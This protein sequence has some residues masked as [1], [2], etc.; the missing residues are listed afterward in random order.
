[1]L[2]CGLITKSFLNS[3]VDNIDFTIRTSHGLIQICH[4]VLLLPL[5]YRTVCERM[6]DSLVGAEQAVEEDRD[7]V[8]RHRNEDSLQRCQIVELKKRNKAL[9]ARITEVSK[10]MLEKELEMQEID[11]GREKAQILEREAHKEQEREAGRGLMEILQQQGL[12]E[13]QN[14]ALVDTLARNELKDSADV[15]A[16]A[17]LRLQ[18]NILEQYV[19]VQEDESIKDKET[20]STLTAE[21]RLLQERAL[22]LDQDLNS[23]LY[24]A[25]ALHED[26]DQGNGHASGTIES[27]DKE[28]EAEAEGEGEE[29]V[30][31]KEDDSEEDQSEEEFEQ[32]RSD[33]HH[34][35]V[36]GCVK[37]RRKCLQTRAVCLESAKGLSNC[38]PFGRS[39]T[40]DTGGIS[41]REIDSQ[42]SGDSYSLPFFHDEGDLDEDC[43]PPSPSRDMQTDDCNSSRGIAKAKDKDNGQDIVANDHDL[44]CGTQ[45]CTPTDGG[46]GCR[47]ADHLL[48]Q[49]DRGPDTTGT[50]ENDTGTMEN[51]TGTVE[52]NA[53]CASQLHK[54]Q[55]ADDSCSYSTSKDTSCLKEGEGE[56]GLKQDRSRQL[57]I[58]NAIMCSSGEDIIAM[59]YI[60]SEIA[61]ISIR[62][63]VANTQLGQEASKSPES[64][65]DCIMKNFMCPS[66]SFSVRPANVCTFNAHL[67]NS[68]SDKTADDDRTHHET[69]IKVE[70]GNISTRISSSGDRVEKFRD[71]LNLHVERFEAL[72]VAPVKDTETSLS[73][74]HRNGKMAVFLESSKPRIE[75]QPLSALY[76]NHS[77]ELDVES[78][79][80]SIGGPGVSQSRTAPLSVDVTNCRDLRRNVREFRHPR[81]IPMKGATVPPHSHLPS[82]TSALSRSGVSVFPRYLSDRCETSS[83]V[84]LTEER[85]SSGKD[86]LTGANSISGNLRKN[87][88]AGPDPEQIRAPVKA[89]GNQRAVSVSDQRSNEFDRSHQSKTKP[90]R[91]TTT[92]TFT[93]PTLDHQ[94]ILLSEDVN[95]HGNARVRKVRREAFDSN[96]LS[97]SSEHS[98]QYKNCC[99]EVEYERYLYHFR[100]EQDRVALGLRAQAQREYYQSVIVPAPAPSV[101]AVVPQSGLQEHFP[102][103][104]SVSFQVSSSSRPQKLTQPVHPFVFPNDVE[105]QQVLEVLR[106]AKAALDISHVDMR[107]T[108]TQQKIIDLALKVDTL[109]LENRHL[110]HY[111]E[112]SQ[113][114]STY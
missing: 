60:V 37:L 104:A 57:D 94:S 7:L 114:Q 35:T 74:D 95:C 111:N 32:S 93:P 54:Y 84:D 91:A 13:E 47:S 77:D 89:R 33:V 65:E 40:D 76:S 88:D 98:E 90:H 36:K 75:R 27:W 38:N 83:Y 80:P 55:Q 63:I 81:S 85:E 68:P 51:N 97:S 42:T 24:R 73:D 10:K 69:A 2:Y 12:L 78:T 59:G 28:N 25:N 106:S 70:A 45:G 58:E 15:D 6:C 3:T 23:S 113:A 30:Y 43:L 1:M 71:L 64:A 48:D 4:I 52:N 31:E 96:T 67:Q 19:A 109:Q 29:S 86:M 21:Y 62:V 101:R 61:P 41:S 79:Y 72:S 39:N 34:H 110:K 99:L 100:R 44:N 66:P 56:G 102:A 17:S 14:I 82:Y 8:D 20:I 87:F 103:T 50:M 112:T 26:Q 53:A 108:Y 107:H 22:L 5:L 46:D 11:M 16:L 49:P 9:E 105:D 18:I 92:S